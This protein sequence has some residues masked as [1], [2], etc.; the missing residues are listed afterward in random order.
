MYIFFSYIKEAAQEKDDEKKRKAGK[1]LLQNGEFPKEFTEFT[2]SCPDTP[3]LKS[4]K[5]YRAGNIGRQRQSSPVRGMKKEKE[6]LVDSCMRSLDTRGRK[7][8]EQPVVVCSEALKKALKRW[9]IL[10]SSRP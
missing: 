9:F 1:A 8:H 2:E 5:S 7:E 3:R 6:I 10:S 4:R